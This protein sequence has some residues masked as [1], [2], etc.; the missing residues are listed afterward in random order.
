MIGGWVQKACFLSMG[1]KHDYSRALTHVNVPVLIIHG[2]NDLIP[3]G[4]C[5]SYL[6]NIQTA[7]LVVIENATHFPFE[8]NSNE[9]ED[10]LA[11]FLQ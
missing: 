9:F 10:V 2:K 6:D 4:T 7:K 1:K 3:V 11:K 5:N 8:E